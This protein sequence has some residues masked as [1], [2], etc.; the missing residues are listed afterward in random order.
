MAAHDCRIGSYAGA[1]LYQRFFIVF[2]PFRIGCTGRQIIGENAGGAAEHIILQLH[3][4]I[5]GNVVLNFNAVSD[6]YMVG[7]IHILPQHTT[8][9]D[10]RARLYMT[11][12]PYL[13][14]FTDLYILVYIT[15]LVNKI[16]HL[17]ISP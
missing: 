16:G 1:F 10:L 17:K 13:R 8:A 6:F 11:E 14:A 12:M 15:A 3:S 7:D 4:F 2:P 5:E 9:S